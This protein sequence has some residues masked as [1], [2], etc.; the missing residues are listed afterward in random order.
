[1]GINSYYWTADGGFDYTEEKASID[2]NSPEGQATVAT[3]C[4]L[5]A[6]SMFND[7][8][9]LYSSDDVDANGDLLEANRVVINEEGIAW[10]SDILYKFNNT[11][12]W[13]TTPTQWMDMTNGK[14]ALF[15]TLFTLPRTLHRMDENC[16]ST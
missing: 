6:K 10:E 15:F 13:Q 11:Y 9:A 14:Q 4:G 2:F 16:W 8:F 5:I 3:P 1:M 12:N 7:T